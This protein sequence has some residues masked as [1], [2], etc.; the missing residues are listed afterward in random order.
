MTPVRSYDKG[1]FHMPVPIV[2]GVTGH[3]DLREKDVPRLRELVRAELQKLTTE[4]PHSP[5]VMLNSLADGADLLCAEVAAELGISLKCPLPMSID[6]YRLGFDADTVTHMEMMLAYADDVFVAPS[7]EPLPREVNRDYYYRQAGIYVAEHSHVLLALWDGSTAKSDGCGTAETVNFMMR[8]EYKGGGS[9]KAV[10]DGAV[11]HIMTAREGSD[12]DLPVT[13]HLIENEPCSLREILLMTDAFNRDAALLTGSPENESELLPEEYIS[14]NVRLKCLS[15]LYHRADSLSL[16]FQKRYLRTIGCFSAFGVLLVLSFLLYDELESDIFLLCYG[17]IIIIYFLA[18]IFARKSKAHKYYLQ[19]RALSEA[20][21][22][23]F[24]LS[25]TGSNENIGAS[26]TWTQKQESTWVK[27]AVSASL[28]G[29]PDSL[30]IPEELIKEY[31]IDGQLE[32]HRRALRRNKRKHRM[33]EKTARIMLIISI[34]LFVV[35][36]AL[37]FLFTAVITKKIITEPLPAIFMQHDDQVFTLR[38]LLKIVLGG[39]SAITVFLSG[40]YGKLSLGR[41]SLDH[42]KM[43][44]LYA[45]AKEQFERGNVNR[46]RLFF[47]LAREEIIENGNWFSYCRENSPTFDV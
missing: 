44:S 16:R 23:Q 12:I 37:E 27:E 35:V 26:F 45:F 19:Y 15:E 6:D 2:I 13:A 17:L 5:L 36:F 31:W 8:G 11:I 3:R 32:Y 10:N 42:E 43:A 38:S 14:G 25:A 33:S 47:E 22:V 46:E 41:K 40:Y 20:M 18:F 30:Q 9:F 28:I 1:D 4:Y 24:Y 39:V 7:V 21:R 34:T 29:S